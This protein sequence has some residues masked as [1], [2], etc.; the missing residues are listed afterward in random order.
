MRCEPV[1]VAVNGATPEV[2]PEIFVSW[3]VTFSVDRVPSALIDVRS[4]VT[5]SSGTSKCEGPRP[6]P[7]PMVEIDV[8]SLQPQPVEP[9]M[10]SSTL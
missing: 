6:W 7:R 9:G 4:N 10:A 5:P 3:R 8:S 2:W 1:S